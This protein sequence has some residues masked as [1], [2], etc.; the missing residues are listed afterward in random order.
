[1]LIK[2]MNCVGL[3]IGVDLSIYEYNIDQC[4]FTSTKRS[5]VIVIV[6]GN[7]SCEVPVI[8]PDNSNGSRGGRWNTFER[9]SF[10]WSSGH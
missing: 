9:V 8:Q 3:H 2:A 10:C 7:A 5:K 4:L 6:S 1:M